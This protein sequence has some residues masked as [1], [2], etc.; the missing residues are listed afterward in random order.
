MMT[1]CPNARAFSSRI[2]ETV[3]RK[4]H[5]SLNRFFSISSILGAEQRRFAR[6]FLLTQEFG[7]WQVRRADSPHTSC[8]AD[9]PLRI[10]CHCGPAVPKRPCLARKKHAIRRDHEITEAM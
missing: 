6:A 3:T 10:H 4:D 1:T 7:R 5:A 2:N 8:D 9:S